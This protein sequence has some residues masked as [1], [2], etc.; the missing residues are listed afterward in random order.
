MLGDHYGDRRPPWRRYRTRVH[1]WL[2]SRRNRLLVLVLSVFLFFFVTLKLSQSL[3]AYR[4]RLLW[5]VS[6]LAKSEI[7][8]FTTSLFRETQRFNVKTPRGIVLP[9]F[10]DIALL[11]FSLLL[12]LGRFQVD[13]PVEVPHCGDLDLKLQI[14][15]KNQFQSIR[16]YDVC[17]LAASAAIHERKLFCVDLDHCH[18]KPCREAL[19]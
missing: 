6:P 12:E 18:H 4:R 8:S 11:G 10:D 3:L 5:S 13:L 16:F 19:A 15:I 1:L 9:L 7:Q 14:L 17:E 2:L